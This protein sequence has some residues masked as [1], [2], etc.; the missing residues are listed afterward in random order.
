MEASPF[1]DSSNVFLSLTKSKFKSVPKKRRFK[2]TS[3]EPGEC[4]AADFLSTVH[5][6][7]YDTITCNIFYLMLG[8]YLNDNYVG[9]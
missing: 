6:K 5:P 9:I 2:T 4:S 7:F 8:L 3:S 1:G